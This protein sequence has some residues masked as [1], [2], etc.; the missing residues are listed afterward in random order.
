LIVREW[1]IDNFR[2]TIHGGGCYADCDGDG[3]LSID[4][5]ICFQTLFA[6]G[7]QDAD[8][9]GDTV[10]SIDDFICFQTSFAIGCP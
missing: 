2:V 1:G 6:L 7:S 9:D 10:L 5:F 4:D 3:V 8:C